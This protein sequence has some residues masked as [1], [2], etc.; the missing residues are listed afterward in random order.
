MFFSK[1]KLVVGTI[2]HRTTKKI[3]NCTI[4]TGGPVVHGELTYPPL[5]SVGTVM[6]FAGGEK[7]EERHAVLLNGCG[8]W[9]SA[10]K[11]GTAEGGFE[12]LFGGHG[13]GNLPNAGSALG[14]F[15]GP[16]SMEVALPQVCQVDGWSFR[17]LCSRQL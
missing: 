6:V 12:A 3:F 16:A 7:L 5:N 2:P 17:L 9:S 13:A 15:I 10:V 1:P 14:S 11:G 4:G 8:Q